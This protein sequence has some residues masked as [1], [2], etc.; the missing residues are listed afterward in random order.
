MKKLVVG[1]G[2]PGK[3]YRHSKHNIGFMAVDHYAKTHQLRFKKKAAFLGEIC[4]FD[5][6][7]LLKPHTYMNLSG[8]SV[9]KVLDY[10]DID[11]ED[12]LIIYDDVDLPFSKLRLRYKGGPGGHNGIKSIIQHIHTSEFNRI[13]FGIDKTDRMDMK[14]YVLSDFSKTELKKIDDV[15]S[16]VD[17]IIDDFKLDIDFND[18][19]TKFNSKKEKI[20]VL[21]WTQC[22][23]HCK[24]E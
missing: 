2:N 10:Y 14:E 24:K 5:N 15:L 11:I 21:K 22:Q 1:L 9:Q 19:M 8:Q 3:K 17:Q 4:D 20:S 23:G 7:I 18:I 16:D 13:R 6:L 12:I